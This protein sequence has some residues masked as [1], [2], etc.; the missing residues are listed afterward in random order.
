[1]LRSLSPTKKAM[2]APASPTDTQRR[3]PSTQR[4]VAAITVH[5]GV[6][7][8]DQVTR[9]AATAT[10]TTSTTI[11][12]VGCNPVKVADRPAKPAMIAT[13]SGCRPRRRL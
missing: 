12:P 6:V 5:H 2:S 7:A 1:M 13:T 11:E 9:V 10:I 8:A 4:P 3:R